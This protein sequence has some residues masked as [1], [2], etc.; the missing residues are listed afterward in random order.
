MDSCFTPHSEHTLLGGNER[1]A[2][3]TFA[4]RMVVL[5]SKLP[6]KLLKPHVFDST[7][8]AAI[9]HHPTNVQILDDDSPIVDGYEAGSERTHLFLRGGG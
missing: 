5:Y 8:Q 9:R 6:A 3:I 7:W 1:S 4:P 2:T